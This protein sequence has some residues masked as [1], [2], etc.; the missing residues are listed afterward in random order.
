MINVKEIVSS[1]LIFPRRFTVVLLLFSIS[2][3]SQAGPIRTLNLASGDWPPYSQNVE[4]NYGITT[5]IVI[6]AFEAMAIEVNIKW[7]PWKRGEALLRSGGVFASFPYRKSDSRAKVY[8]FSDVFYSSQHSKMKLFYDA[9]RTK[10]IPFNAMK[11]L[12]GVSIGGARGFNYVSILQKAGAKLQLVN[13]DQQLAKMLVKGRIDFAVMDTEV[14]WKELFKLVGD[15]KI[16]FKTL[17]RAV[18]LGKKTRLMVSRDYPNY[19]YWTDQFNQGLQKIKENGTH[20]LILQ[21]YPE[22]N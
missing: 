16:Q 14:G 13:T 17:P 7:L 19:R 6:A 22:L 18:Y 2:I 9:S 10:E 1:V 3:L 4:N 12:Q 15:L 11:D 5:D 8:D 20:Q 21:K